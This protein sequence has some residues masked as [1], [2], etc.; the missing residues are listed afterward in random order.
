MFSVCVLR[1]LAITTQSHHVDVLGE[2][3]EHGKTNQITSTYIYILGPVYTMDH[4]FRP[5][6]MAIF[7][8][9]T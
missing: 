4:E 6:K 5:W 2:V 1:K 9:P 3:G 7:H 8:G